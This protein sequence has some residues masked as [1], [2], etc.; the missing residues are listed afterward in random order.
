M[1]FEMKG[2][3]PKCIG[4]AYLGRPQMT[5]NNFPKKVRKFEIEAY[6]KPKNLKELRGT[7]VPFT[8]SPF[9]DPNDPKKVILIPDPYSSSPFYYKFKSNDITFAEELPSIVN[10]EGETI[11]MVRFWVKKMSQ[12]MVCTPFLVE[13]TKT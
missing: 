3:Y 12:G 4:K 1:K 5:I 6:E 9:K 7:H 2:W 13:E 11:T 10:M 8:G